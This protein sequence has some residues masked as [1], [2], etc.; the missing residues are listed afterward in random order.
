MEFLAFL[1]G[2]LLINLRWGLGSQRRREGLIERERAQ[3]VQLFFRAGFGL[4]FHR[5]TPM[6]GLKLFV[7]GE[8]TPIPDKWVSIKR[9]IVIAETK[10]EALGMVGFSNEVIEIPLAEPLVLCF[11]HQSED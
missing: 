2:C 4:S 10:E 1:L 3:R 8:S 6:N 7:V 11:E 5:E 9:A